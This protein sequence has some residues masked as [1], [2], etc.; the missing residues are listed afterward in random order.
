MRPHHCSPFSSQPRPSQKLLDSSSAAPPS[1]CSNPVKFRGWR[2][3]TLY[4]LMPRRPQQRQTRP[5]LSGGAVV[6]VRPVALGEAAFAVRLRRDCDGASFSSRTERSARK[7]ATK[8]MRF[9][10]SATRSALIAATMLSRTAAAAAA[11]PAV[12]RF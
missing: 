1:S 11:A 7:T 4:F 9:R 2:S 10:E 8:T 5:T 6:D 3:T 12:A